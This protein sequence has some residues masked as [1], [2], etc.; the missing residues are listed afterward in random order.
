LREARDGAYVLLDDLS[1]IKI[2]YSF[3]ISNMAHFD[4]ALADKGIDVFMY[5]HIINQLPYENQKF[6]WKKIGIACES[7]RSANLKT[8][9]I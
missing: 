6:H 7:K 5:D 9:K 1:D 3:G 2:A 4:Q 8:L